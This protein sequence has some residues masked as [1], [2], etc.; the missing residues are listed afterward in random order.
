MSYSELAELHSLYDPLAECSDFAIN[1]YLGV[2]EFIE[3][4]VL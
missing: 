3:N 1:I 4:Q 2:L